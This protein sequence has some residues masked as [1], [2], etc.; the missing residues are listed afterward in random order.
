MYDH[1][2]AP[3]YLYTLQGILTSIYL[4]GY[5]RNIYPIRYIDRLYRNRRRLD[6]RLQLYDGLR[7]YCAQTEILRLLNV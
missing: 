6:E 5:I 1:V 4:M 3:I 2:D 7:S